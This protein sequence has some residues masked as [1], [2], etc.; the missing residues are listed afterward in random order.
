MGYT[1]HAAGMWEVRNIP[2]ILIQQT[3]KKYNLGDTEMDG[4]T[5]SVWSLRHRI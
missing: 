3:K 2:R 5:M 1:G 4:K